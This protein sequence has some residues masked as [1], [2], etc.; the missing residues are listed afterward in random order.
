VLRTAIDAHAEA[1]GGRASAVLQLVR[2]RCDELTAEQRKASKQAE[3]K[4][5][6]QQ[7]K[8]EKEEATAKEAKAKVSAEAK[9]KAEA[10]AL[11]QQAQAEARA[12]AEARANVEA[13]AR[14]KAQAEAKAKRRLPKNILEYRSLHPILQP[15]PCK[16]LNSRTYRTILET[17]G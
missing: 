4:Q 1:A 6:Q 8:H 7:K 9:A 5:R 10:E 11:A 3:K 2:E 12:K 16:I 14:A 17:S 13:A 15:S